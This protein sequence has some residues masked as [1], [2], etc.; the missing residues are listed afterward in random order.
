[1]V[2]LFLTLIHYTLKFDKKAAFFMKTIVFIFLLFFI[3]LRHEVGGDWYGYLLWYKRIQSEGLSFSIDSI[4]LRDFG[5]NFINWMSEKLGFG[6][7][8]VNTFCG[9][10]FL[11]GLFRLLKQLGNDRRFYL[12]LLISYPYLIMV[13]ANGYT[14]QATALGLVMLS[15]SFLLERSFKKSFLFQILALFFHK[16]SVVGFVS[17]LLGTKKLLN[18]YVVITAGAIILLS[19]ILMPVFERFYTFYVEN[20]MISEGGTLRGLMNMIPSL[21][22]ILFYR[23]F[24]IKYKDSWFWLRISLIAFILSGISILKFTFADRLLLYFSCIQFVTLT[25]LENVLKEIEVKSLV[26]LTII[27]VYALSLIIWLLFAVHA[28]RWLPYQNILLIQL[29]KQ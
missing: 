20:P 28:P 27:F 3:G 8:G 13:V 16:S 15:Y 10:L 21:V 24:R 7:Y 22:Y 6:I 29:T 1:V 14:R 12:G 2:L 5:Y 23:Y 9:F 19:L 26:F 4:L 25:R 11:I 17:F 18:K